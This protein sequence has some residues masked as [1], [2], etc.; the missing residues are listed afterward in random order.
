MAKALLV[1]RGYTDE[2]LNV[3][4][5]KTRYTGAKTTVEFIE[6]TYDY[7]IVCKIRNTRGMVISEVSRSSRDFPGEEMLRQFQNA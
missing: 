2:G 3:V 7:S 4:F 5:S 1:N 6:H